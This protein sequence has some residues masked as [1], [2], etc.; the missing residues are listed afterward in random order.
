ML[1]Q[2]PYISTVLPVHNAAPTL[3]RAID[4]IQAQDFTDWEL[5]L[6]D[7][8]STDGSGT[9]ARDYAANDPRI[10]VCVRPHRGLVPA[11]REGCARARGEFIA[12]MDA[13]DVSYPERL[14][15]QIEWFAANP[16]GGLCGTQVVA[17]GRNIR[18]GRRRYLEWLNS[19]TVHE[20]IDRDVFIECPVAHPTFMMRR[21]AY[22]AVGGYRDFDGPED[23]DLIFRFWHA[24]YRMGNVDQPLLEWHESPDRHSMLSPRYTEAAFRQLK[25]EWLQRSIAGAGRP[26]FQRGAGEVGK[27][28]LREWPAGA[29]EAVVDIRPGKIGQTIH[30]YHVIR[31]EELPP[32][33]ACFFVVAVGTPGARAI[34]RNWCA[35]RGYRECVDYRFIA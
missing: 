34:I 21:T 25:R 29:I 32:P 19:N 18:A 35:D 12:R 17:A 1:D 31:P 27:R 3:A 9:I 6:V 23:Y 26:W 10:H 16:D 20:S 30:G 24:G 13:D 33:G 15:R 28:W 7:D 2:H 8:G 14:S 5:L 11:L 22:E 4:S